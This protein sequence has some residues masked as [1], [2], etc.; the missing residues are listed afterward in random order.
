MENTRKYKKT[1]GYWVYS[2][3]TPD[4]EAYIGMSKTQ[5]CERWKPS[6]YKRT[7][8]EPYINK[9]GW[10]N[11]EHRIIIDGLTKH[12]AEQVEDWFIRK[13]T[14]DGFCINERRSGGQYR[15]DI[16]TYYKQ[17][18]E[19]H[20]EEIKTYQKQYNKQIRY[21]P[22]GKIYHRVS[23]YN[24]RHQ[25]KVIETPLEAKNKYLQTGYIPSYIKNDDL[26]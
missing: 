19:D 23:A 26:I 11:I 5:P 21:T 17:W 15:D 18:Y 13:A 14:A 7:A 25:D 1:T 8:L 6:Q 20:K 12:Q 3:I 4:K 24:Q 22:E 16:K 2:H 9:Y 10:Q